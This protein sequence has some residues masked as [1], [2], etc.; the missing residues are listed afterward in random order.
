VQPGKTAVIRQRFGKHVS[1]A[2]NKHATIEEPPEVVFSMR[3]GSRSYNGEQREI[4]IRS[5]YLAR[6]V[7]M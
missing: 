5:R 2:M 6:L 3:S 1:V 7:N 4:V